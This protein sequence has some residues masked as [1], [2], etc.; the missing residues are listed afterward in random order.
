[1]ETVASVTAV[2]QIL[3]MFFTPGKNRPSTMAYSWCHIVT[4]SVA[5]S[6]WFWLVSDSGLG[7]HACFVTP[8][9]PPFPNSDPQLCDVGLHPREEAPGCSE[10]YDDYAA[11]EVRSARVCACVRVYVCACVR[12]R[13]C[14]RVCVC[15]RVCACVCRETT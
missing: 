8:P 4:M 6:S 1:M 2:P 11:F 7:S 5:R 13:V 14:V 9:P 12:V 3:F 10:E 15:A